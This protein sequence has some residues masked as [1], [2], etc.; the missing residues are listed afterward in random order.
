MDLRTITYI[1]SESEFSRARNRGFWEVMRSWITGHRSHLWSLDELVNTLQP[2]QAVYLGLQDIPLKDIVGSAGRYRDFTRHFLPCVNDELSKERWRTIYTLV[3]SGVGFPPIEVY[4]LGQAY[5][6]QN[7]HHRVS[8]AAYLGW[9]SIQAHVTLL[10]IPWKWPVELEEQS[11]HR[12]GD[13]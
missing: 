5:F 1:R 9:K 8:V 6:V 10:S 11:H 12:K 4:Q 3:V 2:E 13:R 7:G